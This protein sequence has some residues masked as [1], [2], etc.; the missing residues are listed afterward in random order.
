M[1]ILWT[2]DHSPFATNSMAS[3]WPICVIPADRYLI[4][5]GKNITLE[6]ATVA[7]TES[8]NKLA[9]HGVKIKDMPSC[10]GKTASCS[11]PKM[12]PVFSTYLT[13]GLF[14]L[15]RTPYQS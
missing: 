4:V 6:C 1:F 15:A 13:D 14:T 9:L 3:R 11:S 10:G 12:V 5:D 8:F 7:I 2:S